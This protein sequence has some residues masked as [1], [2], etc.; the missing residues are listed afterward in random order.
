MSN[1]F[2]IVILAVIAI[3]FGVFV[4]T[5]NKTDAP[6]ENSSNAQPS[7]HVRGEGAKGVT[8]IEYGDFQ[9]PACKGYFPI[10]EQ[11][12]EKY[13]A[14]I[15]FQFRNFPLV[16]IHNNAFAAHRAAEAADKQGKFWE[17]YAQ[18]YQSQDSWKNAGDPTTFFTGYAEQLGLN[19]EQFKTD[20]ASSAVNDVIN[21]DVREAQKAGADSTPTFVLNGKKVETNPSSLEEFDKLIADAIKEKSTQ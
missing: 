7:N 9:C 19:A 17:M 3:F 8:L 11:V 6:G 18:L 15:T 10:V 16:Q 2:F 14:D 1:R 5:K 13:K 21:A 4:V 12:V 20:M